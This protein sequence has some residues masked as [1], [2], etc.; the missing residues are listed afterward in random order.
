MGFRVL[1]SQPFKLVLIELNGLYHGKQLA[2][3]VK[4]IKMVAHRLWFSRFELRRRRA[5]GLSLSLSL[6]RNEEGYGIKQKAEKGEEA[7]QSSE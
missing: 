3:F 7:S 1:G 2:Q 6:R 5:R 4:P